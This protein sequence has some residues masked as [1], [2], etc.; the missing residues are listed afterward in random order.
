MHAIYWCMLLFSWFWGGESV[1]CSVPLPKWFKRGPETSPAQGL[2]DAP[3]IPARFRSFLQI[4]VPFQ[5]NLPTKF[6]NFFAFFSM[7]TTSN[8]MISPQLERYGKGLQLFYC[9]KFDPKREVHALEGTMTVTDYKIL[10]IYTHNIFTGTY[11]GPSF[12]NPVESRP[13]LE[14]SS[15]IPLECSGIWWS[16]CIPAGICGAWRSSDLHPKT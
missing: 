1:L 10:F 2:S 13:I 8:K 15:A 6:F 9:G 4:L 16:E 14:D 3:H 11:T 5:L 7:K 12:H